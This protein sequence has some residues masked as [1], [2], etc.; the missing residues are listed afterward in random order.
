[1]LLATGLVALVLAIAGAA[2]PLL[3]TTPLLL[4]AAACFARSSERMHRWLLGSPAFG[5]ILRDWEQRGAVRLRVKIGAT[6]LLVA[7]TAYPLVAIDF[8]PWLKLLAATS[9]AAVV[10]FLWTRPS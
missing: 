4:L 5:P 8:A 9:A 7:L 10:L 1:L 2:L 3:P 6:V